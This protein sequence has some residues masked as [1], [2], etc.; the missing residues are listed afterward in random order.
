MPRFRGTERGREPRSRRPVSARGVLVAAALLASCAGDPEAS[1]TRELA[2]GEAMTVTAPSAPGSLTGTE[3]PVRP[4]PS[5][6]LDSLLLEEAYSRAAGM[7]RLHSLLVARHG[8]LEREAYFNGAG[9]RRI[10]NIK[11]ASKA[12]IST[13]VGIAIEEGHLEGL[14]Q[15][16]LDLLP[17]Y[18]GVNGDPRLEAVTVG[19]L[20]GMTAG[21][22]STSG[23]N[24]GSWAASRDW[25]RDALRRPF[26]EEPG[27]RMVYSTGN[28]HL[29]S[30]ILTRATG[31]STLAYARRTLF[32]PLGVTLSPWTR[33]P[34]GVF[35]G[36]NEMGLLPR[37]MLAYGELY[38]NGGMHQG[39][40]VVSAEWIAESWVQRGTSR[41]N[42]HGHGLGWWIR[43]YAGY[44]VFFAWGHGGQYIFLV[45]ELELTVVTTSNPVGD[46]SGAPTRALHELLEQVLIPAAERGDLRAGRTPGS[47]VVGLPDYR[48]SDEAG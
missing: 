21:L 40:R 43:E 11:S 23:R 37:E 9:P 32:E 16:I 17:E 35:L 39:R 15:P 29:L 24:Y 33:D 38:R 45:P 20:L 41:F 19:H 25:V 47:R 8:E 1:V 48:A 4:P 18:R 5:R 3:L 26:S 2:R 46:R 31:Q 44:D 36:G 28:T 12:V 42:G 22:Q 14:D 7:P 6:G 30:A 27:G 13:L 10:A 34:Q